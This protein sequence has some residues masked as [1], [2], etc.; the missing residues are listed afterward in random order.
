MDT[1]ASTTAT[2]DALASRTAFHTCPLC[3]ANCG[4]EIRIGP[5][6]VQVRGDEQDVLSRGFVC[7]KGV[8]IHASD[9]NADRLRWPLVRDRATGLH[10]EVSWQEAF[11]H[12]ERGMA[13]VLAAGDPDAVG[14]YYGTGSGH[15]AGGLYYS[16]MSSA[17]PTKNRYGSS[18]VDQA[19]KQVACALMFG[20]SMTVP[21]PD[22]D[23]CSHLLILGANPAVSN[24]SLFTAPGVLQRMKA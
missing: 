13:P 8:S 20:H 1:L 3:E 9:T 23:H 7:P 19:P 21:I 2:D 16:V 11:E 12:I 5:D 24:G 14:F 17:L 22:I 10:R 15:S 4:L 18:T 6:G